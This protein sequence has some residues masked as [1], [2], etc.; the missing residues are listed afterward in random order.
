MLCIK[1]TYI[2]PDLSPERLIIWPENDPL[3][4][5]EKAFFDEESQ[6]ANRDAI[7]QDPTILRDKNSVAPVA[8]SLP[9][10]IQFRL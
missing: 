8:A 9:L 5:T 1:A 10:Q 7:S 4:A 6:A 3:S 2:Q